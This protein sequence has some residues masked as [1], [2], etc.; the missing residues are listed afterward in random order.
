VGIFSKWKQHK[1]DRKEKRI[2]RNLKTILNFKAIKEDRLAAIDYFCNIEDTSIAVPALLK[3]FEYSLEHGINDTRE[4]ENCLENIASRSD[5]AIPFIQTHIQNTSRIAWPIKALNKLAS[6]D[7]VI[8]SLKSCLD[9]NDIAFDQAKVDKNYDILCYL[10]DYKIPGY[11]DKIKHFLS[12]HDERVRFAAIELLSEQDEPEIAGI[13]EP[14]ITDT[15]SENT[16]IHQVAIEAF[17][18][19]K[20]KVSNPSAITPDTLGA[21][22]SLGKNGCLEK[23]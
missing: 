10:V 21:R 9:F 22:F 17:A 18:K 6:E 16:R 1:A 11:V 8:D 2:A 23:R 15:S 4:K 5:D 19:N 14:F 3:R 12:Y 7:V 20:W 13:I